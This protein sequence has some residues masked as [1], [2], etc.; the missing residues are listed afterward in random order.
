MLFQHPPPASALC[1]SPNRHPFKY[2]P[3]SSRFILY[4]KNQ[5][6]QQPVP[7]Q[8]GGGIRTVFGR[9][10]LAG[11]TTGAG[12]STKNIRLREGGR[13]RVKTIF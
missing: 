11:Y 9:A 3:L 10:A 1:L 5:R 6:L 2:I 7:A 4:D 12:T 8:R 13:I